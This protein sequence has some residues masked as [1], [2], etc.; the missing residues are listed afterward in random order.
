MADPG[1]T[2]V[3]L[4]VNPRA[5]AIESASTTNTAEKAKMAIGIDIAQAI[6]KGSARA[7][8]E[9]GHATSERP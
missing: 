6:Q 8:R 5:R 2:I 7:R 3:V 1:I 9:R 4:P